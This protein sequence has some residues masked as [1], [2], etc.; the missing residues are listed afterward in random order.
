MASACLQHRPEDAP[1]VEFEQTLTRA[2]LAA[3]E[4][5]HRLDERATLA[6]LDDVLRDLDEGWL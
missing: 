3:T 6:P 5:D 2:L 1:F 4:H